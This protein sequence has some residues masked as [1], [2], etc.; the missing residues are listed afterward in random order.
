M[1]EVY[2]VK[3]ELS[4]I[5]LRERLDELY[6]FFDLNSGGKFK[7]YSNDKTNSRFGTSMPKNPMVPIFMSCVEIL[8]KP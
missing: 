4:N 2:T 3:I 8:T 1:C 6:T 5:L 7:Y